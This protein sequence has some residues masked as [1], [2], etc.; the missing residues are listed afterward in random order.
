MPEF[1]RHNRF[2]QNCPICSG[3][4]PGAGPAAA[5]RR[6]APAGAAKT[7][8][9]A[10]RRAMRVSHETRSADDGFSSVLVPGVRSSASAERLAD[11]MAWAAGRL[12]ALGAS[13]PGPYAEVA[14][15]GD[16]EERIWLAFSIAYLGPLE[17]EDAF[18]GVAEARVSWTS[19]EA[20]SLD[21]AV[22]GPRSSHDPARGP[23]TLEAYRAW[24]ARGGSQEA[25]LGGEG[26][27][28]PERRFARAYER[29]S[30]PGLTRDARFDFLVTLGRLGVLEMQ[31]G[32]LALGGDDAVTVAAKRVFGIGDKL[33]LERRAAAL[34]EACEVPLAAL[35]VALWNWGHGGERATLGLRG[36]EIPDELRARA[37]S[38]LGV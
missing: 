26:G 19:G 22:L 2:T 9:P 7:A 16:I 37:R 31:A 35:D 17:E 21:R 27:W 38:A 1:C 28:S 12:L 3:Q 15:D 25:G 6:S 8:K 13:P 32:D 10:S 34:A 14:G 24:A 20:P 4:T 36:L 33:L 11:E 18:L 29:L 23:R 30:L 5:P